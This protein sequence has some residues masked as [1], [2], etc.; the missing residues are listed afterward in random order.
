MYI[1]LS[2][3]AITYFAVGEVIDL[4]TDVSDI[5]FGFIVCGTAGDVVVGFR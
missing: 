1:S 2:G 5:R 4:L 3:N